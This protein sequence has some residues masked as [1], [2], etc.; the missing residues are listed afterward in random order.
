MQ[1]DVRVVSEL[2]VLTDV[3]LARVHA[4][5]VQ[6]DRID[7]YN[8]RV[9]VLLD[10]HLAASIVRVQILVGQQGLHRAVGERVTNAREFGR[11]VRHAAELDRLVEIAEHLECNRTMRALH[12]AHEYGHSRH[13]HTQQGAS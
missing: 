8:V 1:R 13:R 7:A 9:A 5:R 4:G 10:V 2:V 11:L 12:R 3:V 6:L